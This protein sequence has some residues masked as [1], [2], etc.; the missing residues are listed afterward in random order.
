M[1]FFISELHIIEKYKT[2]FISLSKY[3]FNCF[4]EIRISKGFWSLKLKSNPILLHNPYSTSIFSD[5]WI[6][7]AIPHSH[8]ALPLKKSPLNE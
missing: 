7:D 8:T 4:S 1:K 6:R 3:C 2:S 5:P